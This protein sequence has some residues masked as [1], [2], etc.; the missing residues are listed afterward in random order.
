VLEEEKV[1]RK[2]L[3]ALLERQEYRCALTGV[4]LTPDTCGLDHIE[5]LGRGGENAISN[6]QFVLRA[7]NH[8]KGSLSQ[9][10]FLEYCRKI[11]EFSQ[12]PSGDLG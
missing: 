3:R 1:T 9:E 10:D 4:D 12:V 5:P 7:V 2:N 6:C 8:M 11:Y